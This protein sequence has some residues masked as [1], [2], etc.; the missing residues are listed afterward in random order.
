MRL[1]CKLRAKEEDGKGGLR[2][3]RQMSDGKRIKVRE[4]LDEY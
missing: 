1:T 4:V 2:R 3:D